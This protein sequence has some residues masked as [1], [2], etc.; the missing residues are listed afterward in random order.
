MAELYA[1]IML[2]KIILKIHLFISNLLLTSSDFFF[3]CF[4]E[5]EA[6]AQLPGSQSGGDRQV[7]SGDMLCHR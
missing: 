3:F 2:N 1:G 6:R 5:Y 7:Q 4:S